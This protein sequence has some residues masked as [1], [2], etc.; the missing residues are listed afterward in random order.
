MAAEAGGK[1]VEGE[2]QATG[3][4]AVCG[5]SADGVVPGEATPG[6]DAL[7]FT[8]LGGANANVTCLALGTAFGVAGVAS[9]GE[10]PS[11]IVSVRAA[12]SPTHRRPP[13]PTRRPLPPPLNFSF[14][15][16]MW[17]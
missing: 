6:K 16:G 12:P 2:T 10:T 13:S 4:I 17:P 14:S 3:R 5:L 11:C 9:A 15:V 7:L 1:E 8:V